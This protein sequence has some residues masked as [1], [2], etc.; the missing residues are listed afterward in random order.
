MLKNNQVKC[1]T[2]EGVGFVSSEDIKK[3]RFATKR[4]AFHKKAV[5]LRKQ[6][7]SYRQAGKIMGLNAAS[8]RNYEINP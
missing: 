8:V 2:C 1:P 4:E 6:G 7:L 3:E 5:E